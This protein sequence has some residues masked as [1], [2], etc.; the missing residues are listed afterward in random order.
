[1][2]ACEDV[3]GAQRWPFRIPL[4]FD[5]LSRPDHDG[6]YVDLA[7]MHS[8]EPEALIQSARTRSFDA[9]YALI[10]RY[11]RL[12][13]SERE[14]L[15]EAV[16]SFLPRPH[17]QDQP[18]AVT[19]VKQAAFLLSGLATAAETDTAPKG[20]KYWDKMGRDAL[21]EAA[22]TILTDSGAATWSA[23]DRNE[24]S[25]VTLR[26]IFT[27]LESPHAAR[28]KLTRQSLA[29]ILGAIL[30]LDPAQ[31]LPVTTGLIH[32]LTRHEHI[33]SP[34]ADI[35]QRL[36]QD[37]AQDKLVAEIIGEIS[38]L[39]CD[40]LVRDTASA[41][42]C[43]TCIGDL[44][45]RVPKMALN[46]LAVILGLLDGDSYT[47]RNG[48]LHTIGRLLRFVRDDSSSQSLR[49]SLFEILL[50]RSARDTNAFTRSKAM[51]TW[52]FLAQERA[53]P[54]R[55]LASVASVAASRLEDK[56]AA[57]RRSSAQL[58]SIL[59]QSNPF[60]PA[61]RLSH[62]EEKRDS[63]VSQNNVQPEDNK[64]I[65]SQLG[66]YSS[67]C[68]FIASVEAG[69]G[70]AYQMLRSTSISDVSESVGLLVTSVQF[71]LE[72]ASGRA[73]RAMLGLVLAREANIK[74]AAID[75][76]E[77][78]LSP[79]SHSNTSRE[80]GLERER[81]EE[82]DNAFMVA[83][84]LFTLIVGATSGEIA[85]IEALVAELMR[86]EQS[87]VSPAV[88]AIVWDIFSGKVPG[89]SLD[90]RT[91]AC[92]CIG[93]FAAVRPESLQCRIAILERVGLDEN[94]LHYARWTSVAL[95]KLPPKSDSEGRIC[96]KL[97]RIIE[98][99]CDVMT[100]E[101]A[102]TA[103]Y[104]I[105]P[106][107][108][109][110][111]SCMITKMSGLFEDPRNVPVE[112]LSRFLF[113]I[114]HVAIKQLVRIES[115]VGKIRNPDNSNAS[116]RHD[117]EEISAEADK[118]MEFAES[119]LTLPNSLL[120]QYGPLASQ[121]SANG[122]APCELRS[123]AVLCLAKLMCVNSSFCN[124]NLQ[125][126]FT[127]LEKAK[128]PSVRANAVTALGDL[129][130]RFPNLVEPW[131]SRIYGALEDESTRVRKNALM[132]LTHLIL[133]DMVKV[134]GQ[135]VALALRILDKDDRIAELGRLFFH[136]LSRK[137]ANAMYNLLPDTLSCISRR[138]TL[139]CA[140]AHHVMTFLIGFIDKGWQVEGI[141]EKLCHR[142][143]TVETDQESRD[144][145]Y[146]IS[147]MNVTE[148]CITKLSD[149]FK[150]YAAALSNDDVHRYLTMAV[151]KARR[152]AGQAI[153]SASA[154]ETKGRKSA[155]GATEE[156]LAQSKDS[157]DALLKRFTAQRGKTAEV[158]SETNNED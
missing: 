78:L 130:F 85:C 111:I 96:Q 71:Q 7:A 127:V 119:E 4:H 41:R 9:V 17:S 128:E 97:I 117:E 116:P 72:S 26:I 145:A 149:C 110:D 53:I 107:P 152:N 58:L 64:D 80:H 144:L 15:L 11:R 57:V 12:R 99:D 82:K 103:V 6:G 90:Q 62:F 156:S 83:N 98:S 48:V 29:N 56:T 61:L 147:Q 73:V 3:G 69:L 22:A 108:E 77:R 120:G 135:M 55:L 113:V 138:E 148:R 91:A 51:Q 131:S 81:F 121:I 122:M 101:Q 134:K 43:A 59:L 112:K 109:N 16:R 35:L 151:I 150:L 20:R 84:G 92:A 89:A 8:E 157:A 30:Q 40:H 104:C 60:G 140:D 139:S 32:L 155:N 54:H 21:L 31:H 118:V 70:K 146:C 100:L 36:V 153:C 23:S 1:M 105:H 33:A 79:K 106:M 88:I 63:L 158:S 87:I 93:M 115:L 44:A 94:D 38:R 75:A 68:D 37:F 27:F 52:T 154:R 133:N 46:N 114:G 65:A 76:Y 10:S 137:S 19:E 141:L 142:F 5:D 42:S 34:M 132:A 49:D 24:L 86:R 18:L 25:S 102:L 28:D 47:M 2:T 50:E 66:F 74:T 143:R 39:D 95:S 45:E 14:A 136:E 126:L 67:A 124:A 125:L 123:S 129:A 13:N